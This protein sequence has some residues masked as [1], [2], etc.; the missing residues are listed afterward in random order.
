MLKKILSIPPGFEYFDIQKS[1][2]INQYKEK[3]RHI[4]EQQNLI[5]FLPPLMDYTELFTLAFSNGFFN[6]QKKLFELKD[7]NGER[8]AVR[9][10]LTI[11]AIKSFLI[12]KNHKNSIKYYYI[13][14]VYRDL[15]KGSGFS[16]E[17]YQV[18]VE[19][20][21]N[22]E[23]RIKE[24]YDI[25]KKLLHIFPQNSIQPLF[26]IGNAK[27]IQKLLEYLPENIHNE[28]LF[29]FYSKNINLLYDICKE[30]HIERDL[31]DILI[32]LPLIIGNKQ[33]IKDDLEIL[34]KRYNL[35]KDIVNQTLNT[36]QDEDILYDFSLIKE[37]SYYTG[38]V[39]N[40]YN[41]IKNS[42]I[43]TGGIYDNLSQHFTDSKVPACGF[44]MNLSEIINQIEV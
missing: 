41:K 15:K 17:I 22:F 4:L 39:F 5:E 40:V 32:E 38:I 9:S 26:V 33:D 23:N 21:G 20:I 29:A 6:H 2:K 42:L 24:L 34:L 35:L 28:L 30:Y 44:A 18:G 36:L 25:A 31:K 14:P 43:I 13:Q 16:R 19:W 10:D 27:F 1:Q 8:I 37:F 12:H 11:M 3:I 7:A